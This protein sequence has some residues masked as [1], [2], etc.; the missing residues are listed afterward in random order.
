VE[1]L[2]KQLDKPTT[3]GL[4][5]KFYSLRYA[6]ASDL[7]GKLRTILAGPLQTQLGSVTTYNADDRTNQ[8]VLVTDPRQYAFF[9]ELIQKLDVKSDPNTR[10]DVIPLNHAKAVDVVNVLTRIIQGQSQAI[11]AQGSASARA[12]TANQPAQPAARSTRRR[13]RRRR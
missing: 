12:G 4:K 9:D 2:L 6:K 1:V 5:P 13:R 3:G 7:V 8:I 11:R 10:N